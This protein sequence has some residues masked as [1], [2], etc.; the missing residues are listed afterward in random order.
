[1]SSRRIRYS[2]SVPQLLLT[3]LLSFVPGEG[4]LLCPILTESCDI[5][6]CYDLKTTTTALLFLENK[7]STT[8]WVIIFSNCEMFMNTNMF[9]D[10]KFMSKSKALFDTRNITNTSKYIYTYIPQYSMYVPQILVKHN[11]QSTIKSI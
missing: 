3:C 5:N 10:Y 1:M 7:S 6:R 2:W 11:Q 4:M 9:W 8:H